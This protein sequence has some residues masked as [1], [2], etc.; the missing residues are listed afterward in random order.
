MFCFLGMNFS[1]GCLFKASTK[2][3]CSSR[4]VQRYVV[5]AFIAPFNLLN[6]SINTA[7]MPQAQ[8]ELKKVSSLPHSPYQPQTTSRINH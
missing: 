6:F 5:K 3:F 4:T 1:K 2:Y 8:P 7:I